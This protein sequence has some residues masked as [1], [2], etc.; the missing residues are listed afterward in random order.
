MDWHFSK[1]SKQATFAIA[2]LTAAMENTTTK[3]FLRLY[4]M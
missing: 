1:H 2:K 4:F 3:T